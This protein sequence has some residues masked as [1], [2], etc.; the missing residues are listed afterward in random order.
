MSAYVDSS[1]VLRILFGDG[2]T[3][4]LTP[5]SCLLTS[6]ITDIECRLASADLIRNARG[7]ESASRDSNDTSETT[8]TN[9]EREARRSASRN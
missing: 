4:D 8:E 1:V 3:L 5:Y 2:H 9:D 7:G 6:E